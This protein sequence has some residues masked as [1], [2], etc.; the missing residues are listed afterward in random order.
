M[1]KTKR[2]TVR[3]VKSIAKELKSADLDTVQQ[4]VVKEV[5]KEQ[6]IYVFEDKKALWCYLI[7]DPCVAFRELLRDGISKFC[8]LYEGECLKGADRHMRLLLAWNNYCATYAVATM[9]HVVQK[10]VLGSGIN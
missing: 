10:L 8:S 6:H 3:E 5:Q 2:L 7:G 4:V 9:S 1:P